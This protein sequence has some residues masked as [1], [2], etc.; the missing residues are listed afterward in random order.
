MLQWP[1]AVG[2]N[3][4]V[5]HVDGGGA[6]TGDQPGDAAMGDGA[7]DA[8]DTNRADWRGDEKTDHATFEQQVQVHQAQVPGLAASSTI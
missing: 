1:D 8:Q 3:E 6:E 2:G 5:A 7:A 4:A